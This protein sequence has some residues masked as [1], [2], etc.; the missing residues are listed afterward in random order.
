[1]KIAFL[2]KNIK[3]C[4]VLFQR[5]VM[6]DLGL[7]KFGVYRKLRL[8]GCVIRGFGNDIVFCIFIWDKNYAANRAIFVEI[9]VIAL[10]LLVF[11]AVRYAL[12]SKFLAFLALP[13]LA[14]ISAA[15]M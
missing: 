9:V 12:S 14:I 15:E 8:R 10:V 6:K 1:M 4:K 13:T 3:I 7:L 11:M 5:R 2:T